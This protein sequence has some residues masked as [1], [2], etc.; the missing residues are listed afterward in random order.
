M[1][2]E[3]YAEQET[4]HLFTIESV[5]VIHYREIDGLV[6]AINESTV[7]ARTSGVVKQIYYDINDYVPAGSVI[8]E[9]D[10]TA[11]TVALDRA[12]AQLKEAQSAVNEAQ[13]QFERLRQLLSRKAVSQSDYDRSKAQYEAAQAR[14]ASA[15][16]G[17]EQA[18]LELDYTRITAPYAGLV[19][20]RQVELGEKVL[21]GTTL[22]T[23]LSLEQLRILG[24]LPQSDLKW[25]ANQKEVDVLLPDGEIIQAG[26]VTLYPYADA[27]THGVRFRAPLEAEGQMV[28]PGMLLKIRVPMHTKE[29]IRIPSS[30]LVRRTELDAVYVA[31]AEGQPRLRM[32]RPGSQTGDWIEI[33]S[34]LYAGDRVFRSALEALARLKTSSSP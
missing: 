30:S 15:Q 22:M 5:E 8:I 33:E 26:P 12:N 14:L 25:I 27:R 19:K 21:P 13:I 10:S 2:P 24:D 16:S 6:E 29:V 4:A 1:L 28:F 3:G 7:S 11:Q 23:G 17:V 34:G 32:V 31:N 20:S 18:R 9:L